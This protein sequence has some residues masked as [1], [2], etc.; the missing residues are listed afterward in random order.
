MLL[1]VNFGPFAPV[2]GYVGAALAAVYGIWALIWKKQ[3]WQTPQYILPPAIRGILGIVLVV[4]MIFIWLDTN[5]Q[6]IKAKINLAL[7]FVIIAV[8][9]FVLYLA[10]LRVLTY[11]KEEAISA[12]ETRIVNVIGGLWLK[13]SAKQQMINNGVAT[14]QDL[15]RGTAYNLDALWSRFSQELSKTIIVILY[16]S[17]VTFGILGITTSGFIVQVKL[18][19]KPASEVI[20]KTDSPGL[21]K[22]KK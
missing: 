1:E 21:D 8:V 4:G 7:I 19:N 17:I 13:K 16:L 9:S 18:T 14:I 11:D 10:L 15:L 12:S 5:P 2:V 20:N 3:V 22:H 6:N